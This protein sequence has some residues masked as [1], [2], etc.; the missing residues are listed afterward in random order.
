[1]EEKQAELDNPVEGWNLSVK[2]VR[3]IL[4]RKHRHRHSTSND[5]VIREGDYPMDDDEE[6]EEGEVGGAREPASRGEERPTKEP[7]DEFP[8]SS[9]RTRSSTSSHSRRLHE[10]RHH[11]DR[12]RHH[13]DRHRYHDDRRIQH[14]SSSSSA[15]V[16]PVIS[17]S[18]VMLA[19]AAASVD[20]SS[21]VAPPGQKA[22]PT[23]SPLPTNQKQAPPPIP[24]PTAL[25]P[26]HLKTPVTMV[27]SRDPR[28]AKRQQ[29]QLLE[30]TQGS[31]SQQTE[32]GTGGKTGAESK[33]P[34][35]VIESSPQKSSETDEARIRERL[36]L[37]QKY[38][39]RKASDRRDSKDDSPEDVQQSPTSVNPS[40][41]KSCLVK[42]SSDTPAS[43]DS[44][45]IEEPDALRSVHQERLMGA[46]STANEQEASLY[47]PRSRQEFG[48]L[49]GEE[50][51]EQST[52]ELE[53]GPHKK[54]VF[55]F[56][57]NTAA[58]VDVTSLPLPI[59]GEVRTSTTQEVLP[60]SRVEPET[61]EV[62]ST[63][64]TS[65]QVPSQAPLGTGSS[66]VKEET[67]PTTAEVPSDQAK[68]E[69]QARTE[70]DND[71][72]D[73]SSDSSDEGDDK[74]REGKAKHSGSVPIGKCY[75]DQEGAEE[76]GG[77]ASD[78]EAQEEERYDSLTPTP[79]FLSCSDLHASF[80]SVGCPWFYPRAG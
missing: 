26:P 40:Q 36:L 15:T 28:V 63:N 43:V 39:I 41:I 14:H 24:Q 2:D 37:R 52:G 11:D 9:R 64:M 54:A 68:S 65:T 48:S 5:D 50:S 57:T 30:K 34:S 19:A 3:K 25:P 32:V 72:K 61:G 73:D 35:P 20:P 45:T 4:G 44:P 47:P 51:V 27:I 33:S 66:L 69:S 67:V 1:M 78:R 74:E 77:V 38:R 6:A 75:M 17:I 55:F 31:T 70:S 29:Q 71:E 56:N 23:G 22:P 7:I 60:D 18:P 49:V 12:H 59:Q 62:E 79:K 10:N 46:R 42:S 16:S 76:G 8:I 13:D 58:P 80:F 21:R 53:L